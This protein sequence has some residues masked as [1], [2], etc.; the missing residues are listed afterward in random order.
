MNCVKLMRHGMCFSKASRRL[1][2]ST[3]DSL[4]LVTASSEAWEKARTTRGGGWRAKLGSVRPWGAPSR[5]QEASVKSATLVLGHKETGTVP[6]NLTR[7]VVSLP[8]RSVI[9]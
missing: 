5:T 7:E 2:I 4:L 3:K 8:V 6:P 9:W 1:Q